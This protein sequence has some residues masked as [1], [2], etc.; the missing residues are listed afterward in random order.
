[1][2][3]LRWDPLDRTWA[4]I[5]TERGRR[6]TDFSPPEHRA[7]ARK[8][9][10]PF[11]LVID[12]KGPAT[13]IAERKTPD[14][15]VLVLANRFPVLAVEAPSE[16]RQVGPYDSVNGVGAHEVVVETLHH[17]RRFRDL[18]PAQLAAILLT[19]RDRVIDLTRDR[20]FQHVEVFKND[21]PSAGATLVHAHSQIVATPVLPPRLLRQIEA[22]KTHWHDKER[23]LVC[24]IVSFE[25]EHSERVID[26]EGDFV[27]WCPYASRYPFAVE[28]ASRRHSPYFGLLDEVQALALAELL[29][30]VLRVLDKALRG[31]DMNLCLSLSP[32]TQSF[33]RGRHGLEQLDQ[34]WHWRIEL[35]PRLLPLG[36]FE[37]GTDLVINPTAP[38]AAAAHLRGLIGG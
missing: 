18:A 17:D 16:R 30:R 32:S 10:C 37:L 5:A 22:A 6:P 12:G 1:M 9:P 24:D 27:A 26:D 14:D 35:I 8:E 29:A 20:R 13:R 2:S 33:A 7:S 21:G 11:C 19:W 34:L 3:E 36:G 38:E 28:L 25:V 23:C 15:A 31:A 4:L